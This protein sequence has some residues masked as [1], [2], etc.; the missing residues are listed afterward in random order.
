M[1]VSGA[2]ANVFRVGERRKPRVPSR[3][4]AR[5]GISAWRGDLRPPAD[6][7]EYSPSALRVPRAARVLL[8]RGREVRGCGSRRRRRGARRVLQDAG[9]E[10]TA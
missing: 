9:V 10:R 6:E 8:A 7:R 4:D 5:A 3:R 2:R 1:F